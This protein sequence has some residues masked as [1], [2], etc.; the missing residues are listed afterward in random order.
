MLLK[1]VRHLVHLEENHH[2]HRAEGLAVQND[3]DVAVAKVH[4]AGQPDR[5]GTK[6]AGQF[7]RRFSPVGFAQYFLYPIRCKGRRRQGN[8]CHRDCNPG[9]TDDRLAK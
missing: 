5:I 7:T 1:A 2:R 6:L 4:C 8:D 9:E 3:I